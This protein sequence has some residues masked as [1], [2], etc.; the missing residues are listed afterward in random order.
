[1]LPG[2]PHLNCPVCSNTTETNDHVVQCDNL[3]SRTEQQINLE[4]IRNWGK[5]TGVQALM[6]SNNLR[7]INTWIRY[8]TFD[9]KGRLLSGNMMHQQLIQAIKEQEKIGWGHALRGRISGTWEKI[10]RM[11]DNKQGRNN[12][13]RTMAI[14]IT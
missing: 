11:D 5:I 3:I 2:H 12:T 10:Q 14:L 8:K 6:M 13:S 7:H 1:M 4:R 9:I